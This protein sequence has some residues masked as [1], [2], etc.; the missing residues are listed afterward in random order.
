[1]Q[2]NWKYR[3]YSSGRK[4]SM[5]FDD[6]VPNKVE[7]RIERTMW[8]SHTIPQTPFKGI[9]I[10][11]Y[12]DVPELHI[13]GGRQELY[14]A[15][16]VWEVFKKSIFDQWMYDK[17]HVIG[18]SSGY[19]SRMIAKAIKELTEEHGKDWLGETWFVECGGEGNGF[20]AIMEALEFK[21]YVIWEL[22]YDFEYFVDVHERFNGLCAY[23]VNQWYDFYVKQWN[24]EDIQYISGYGGNIADAM[25]PTAWYM[26]P[27]KRGKSIQWILHFYF[28]QQYYYQLSAFKKPKYSFH[29]FWSW[30]Y[31]NAASNFKPVL[32]S[33]GYNKSEG[34]T[35]KYLSDIFVLEC[36]HIPRND[37]DY[38]IANGG[39]LLK[40]KVVN[41]LY[42]WYISTNYGRENLI[43]PTKTIEYNQWWLQFCI[44]SYAEKNNISIS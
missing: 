36:K 11:P 20:K 5:N 27:V 13:L 29:P 6:V 23:P 18:S 41:E 15:E 31:I 37:T 43:K 44:A 7:V 30:A 38:V 9:I 2:Y 33:N 12:M 39:R 16:Y 25:N 34:R 42:D 1:M 19:D 14:N 3:I 26:N 17:I 32:N 8:L 4:K 24:E 10:Y 21:N 40:K 28:K 22:D 35:S